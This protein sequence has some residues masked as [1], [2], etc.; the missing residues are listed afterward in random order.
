[1]CNQTDAPGGARP[2]KQ[3]PGGGA[4]DNPACKNH[5]I[6]G[7]LLPAWKP[8]TSQSSPGTLPTMQMKPAWKMGLPDAL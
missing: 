4:S 7:V 2:P 1:M 6:R 3:G 8:K 5:P